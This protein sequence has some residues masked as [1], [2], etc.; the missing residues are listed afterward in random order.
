MKLAIILNGN[1]VENVIVSESIEQ[2]KS[3]LPHLYPENTE[4][5]TIL[6]CETNNISGTGCQLIDGVW[7]EPGSVAVL[8]WVAITNGRDNYLALSDWTQLPD[9]PI[10]SEKKQE[11]L[12]Y[13]QA[14]RDITSTFE[15]PKDVV[16]PTPPSK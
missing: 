13:R 12:E 15:N 4:A 9:A 7:E 8:G 1:Y 2:A 6:D 3:F 5:Y 10:T 16:F 11:W 14:L